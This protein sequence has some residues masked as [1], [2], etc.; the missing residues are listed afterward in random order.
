MKHIIIGVGAAGIS[1]ARAIRKH[2]RDDEILMISTD[3]AVYSRCM[4]HKYIGGGRSVGEMS[5]VPDNFFED[6]NISWRNRTTVTEIDTANKRV[7][8]EGGSEN[9]DRLLIAT[10]AKSVFPP[11]DGLK[12]AT[13]IYGLRDLPDAKAIREKAGGASNIVVIGA[14]LVGLDAAY[15]LVEMGKKPVVVDMA[16]HVLSANLDEPAAAVYQAKFEEAG[17]EFR[18]GCKVSSVKQNAAGEVSAIILDGK[19]ELACD[20]LVVAVG[21]RPENG[22]LPSNSIDEYLSVGTDVYVAGDA[23]GFS[24]SWPSA[25]EQ[26]EV[27]ALNMCGIITP[28]DEI[29]ALKNTVNFFG[30]ASLSV[31][32]LVPAP[33]DTCDVRESKGR[34]QK[35]ISRD[36]VPVG[37]ILQGDISRSGF[38]QHLVKNKINI[39]DIPKPIWKMSFADSYG[40]D[41]NGEYEWMT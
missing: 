10:G 14:G 22:L 41:E 40:L 33:G 4:L 1:A 2:R 21:V 34:Y 36:G 35:I 16:T 17:C 7:V 9:Y 24:Q 13:G 18:F 37:V 20:L 30:I 39:A 12:G 15:G 23:T 19:E 8:F 28:Y 26:G 27:A 5:F 11:I 29:L 31:G 6:N 32:Q 3:D 38:W 25:I